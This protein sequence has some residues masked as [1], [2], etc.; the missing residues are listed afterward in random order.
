VRENLQIG[1]YLRKDKQGIRGDLDYVFSLFPILGGRQRQ[2]AGNLSGGEQ[3]M[4]AIG[5]ALMSRPRLL[6]MDEPSLGLA[7]NLV[8]KLFDLLK[9]INRDGT[10]IL[11]VEQNASMALRLSNRA[12]VLESGTIALSGTGEELLG[13][14]AVQN[15]YLGLAQ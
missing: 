2:A 9:K 7:P 5:R 1:A 11:L 3:M 4:L 15:A 12:Y 6:L 14:E 10:T 8:E 13:N